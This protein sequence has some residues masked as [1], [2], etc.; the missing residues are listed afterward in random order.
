[1]SGSVFPEG[2]R[3]A[4]SP[5][6]AATPVPCYVALC[7]VVP[8]VGA[9]GTT[10][11]EPSADYGYERVRYDFSSD[12]WHELDSDTLANTLAVTFPDAV[13]EPWGWVGGWALAS[14]RDGGVVYVAGSLMV[15][16]T[17]DV[18]D[19]VVFPPKAMRFGLRG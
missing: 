12:T 4:L 3:M 15:S 9:D 6:H 16:R 13:N 17:V 1:M 19:R 8:P 14:G 7:R 10:L 11:S 2:R 5:F 18:G